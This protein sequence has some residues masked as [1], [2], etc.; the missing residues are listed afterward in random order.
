VTGGG[1]S[2]IG[3]EAL[4]LHRRYLPSSAGSLRVLLPKPAQTWPFRRGGLPDS[5]ATCRRA[6]PAVAP[7]AA[8]RTLEVGGS[9]PLGS[10]L[11]FHWSSFVTVSRS[12]AIQLRRTS[13]I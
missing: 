9:T 1:T 11:R 5:F 3:R 12:T 2:E 4:G 13:S 6:W 10:T 7:P 8:N